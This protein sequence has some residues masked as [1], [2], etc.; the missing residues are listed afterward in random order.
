MGAGFDNGVR[1]PRHEKF[2]VSISCTDRADNAENSS[3]S[4]LAKPINRKG[5]LNA[6]HGIRGQTVHPGDER[7]KSDGGES[8]GNAAV[9]G[10]QFHFAS[11]LGFSR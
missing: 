4:E 5:S 1:E 2:A 9:R 3:C 6:P 7:S 11:R 10:W 8:R